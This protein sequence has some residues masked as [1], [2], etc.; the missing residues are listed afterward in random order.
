MFPLSA[1]P[2]VLP[3]EHTGDSLLKNK[4]HIEVINKIK[5]ELSEWKD[6]PHSWIERQYYQDV[7]PFELDL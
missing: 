2:S 6:M 5:E 3:W 7:S 1:Y 4:K